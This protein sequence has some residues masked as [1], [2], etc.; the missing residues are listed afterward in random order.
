MRNINSDHQF[1]FLGYLRSV[2]KFSFPSGSFAL[3]KGWQNSWFQMGYLY[4]FQM[5]QFS[6]SGVDTCPRIRVG[7][8]HK[9]R[10]GI[11]PF[12]SFP[13]CH[14]KR[15]LSLGQMSHF[16]VELYVTSV[17]SFSLI[18]TNR[19]SSL[20]WSSITL[21]YL[22]CLALTYNFECLGNYYK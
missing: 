13:F 2:C 15:L 5:W 10:W 11:R 3:I 14:R 9:S 19:S 17:L 6:R 4:S 8:C 7:T 1:G 22:Y 18:R 20:T 12:L 16:K 21:E